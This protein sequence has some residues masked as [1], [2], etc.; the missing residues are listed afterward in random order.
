MPTRSALRPDVATWPIVRRP[1]LGQG[2]GDAA[3]PE[4]GE[5]DGQGRGLAAGDAPAPAPKTNSTRPSIA[6]TA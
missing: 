4:S 5:L 6:N 1:G 2:A 3:E